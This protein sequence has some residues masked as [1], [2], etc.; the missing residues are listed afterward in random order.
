MRRQGRRV[1]AEAAQCL[2]HDQRAVVGLCFQGG[3]GFT[4]TLLIVGFERLER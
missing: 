4:L 1:V 3:L 2:E